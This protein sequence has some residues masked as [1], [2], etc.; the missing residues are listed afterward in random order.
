MNY[1]K[2]YE[3]LCSRGQVRQLQDTYV[4][5]HHIVPKCLGG[6]NTSEN[7]TTLTAR[8][9]FIAHWL[10]S[11]MYPKDRKIQLAFKMMC[12]VKYGRR[13]TP[14]S[15]VI[16]EARKNVAILNSEHQTGKSRAEILG[17]EKAKEVLAK[18]SKT[19]TG[20]KASVETRKKISVALTGL[21]RPK[22]K[23]RV[24]INN[25]VKAKMV[26]KEDLESYLE[27]G[28]VLGR[29]PESK[30]TVDRRKESCAD[31]CWVSNGKIRTLVKREVVTEY[32]NQ[33][34]VLGYK[35]NTLNYKNKQ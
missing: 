6:A 23:N 11:R 9:H 5:V 8:E 17:E 19:K 32:L 24:H 3:L 30:G 28:W 13:Y 25:K 7:L 18:I 26:P 33:G 4:E 12:D 35:N 22:L 2:H 16:A 29:L 31:R 20:S 14:S 21:P 1:A 10:L 34:Y 15:R 27:Q